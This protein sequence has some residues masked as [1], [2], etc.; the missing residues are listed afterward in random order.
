V[1]RELWLV[2]SRAQGAAVD[3]SPPWHLVT[4]QQRVWP[5]VG[6]MASELRCELGAEH[7]LVTARAEILAR[8]LDCD[9][10]LVRVPYTSRLALVHLTWSGKQETGGFPR[11]TAFETWAEWNQWRETAE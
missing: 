5:E 11:T 9:D 10:V 7:P 1:S 8:R 4:R 6:N 3:V 2:W